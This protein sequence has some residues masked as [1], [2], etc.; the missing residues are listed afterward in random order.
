M[1]C[2]LSLSLSLFSV[3]HCPADT[4]HTTSSSSLKLDSCIRRREFVSKSSNNNK[5]LVKRQQLIHSLRV[6]SV[7]ISRVFGRARKRGAGRERLMSASTTNPSKPKLPFDYS[8]WDKIDLSDD[9]DDFHPNIDNASFIRYA[10]RENMHKRDDNTRLRVF[11]CVCGHI[12]D[13]VKYMH[14]RSI[15][16]AAYKTRLRSI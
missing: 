9:E 12:F 10:N 1:Q 5:W 3:H 8:K 2:T 15:R 7:C 4:H 11:D 6:S 16:S 13:A 14:A